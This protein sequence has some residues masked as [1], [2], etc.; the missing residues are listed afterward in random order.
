MNEKM[1]ICSNC[2][3][4]FPL[5]DNVCPKCGS[6][7]FTKLIQTDTIKKIRE[8]KANNKKIIITILIYIG[9]VIALILYTII[10]IN[11]KTN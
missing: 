6:K 1:N 3:T 7:E 8:S 4:G 11:I 10:R 5:E 9:V 2:N